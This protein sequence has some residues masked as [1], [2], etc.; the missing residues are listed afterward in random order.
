MHV[1][2]FYPFTF[3]MTLPVFAEKVYGVNGFFSKKFIF[4][5]FIFS[6]TEIKE[7]NSK[8]SKLHNLNLHRKSSIDKNL[9]PTLGKRGS[10][11]L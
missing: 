7:D 6:K 8:G 11:V 4:S 9:S 10:R 2:Y 1:N 5:S 3:G